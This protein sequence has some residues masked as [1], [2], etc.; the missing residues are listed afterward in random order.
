MS[1]ELPFSEINRRL[2][3]WACVGF[4][5]RCARREVALAGTALAE[6]DRAT[7][8]AA[9]EKA[10]DAS[11]RGVGPFSIDSRAVSELARNDCAPALAARAAL[12]AVAAGGRA[13]FLASDR[14][15]RRA[16]VADAAV[17]VAEAASGKPAYPG[18][19]VSV[20]AHVYRDFE[21]LAES[22]K[23]EQWSDYSGIPPHYFALNTEFEIVRSPLI[24]IASPIND[25]FIT[26]LREHPAAMRRMEPRAFE[27]LVARFFDGFGFAVE[28]T[29]QCR[30]GGRDV[31]A[32]DDKDQRKYLI[33]CKRYNTRKVGIEIVQRL[34]GV[35]AGEGATKG[36]IATTSA[37]T[38][39]A[40]D[41]LAL[42]TV[43]W[44]LEGRDFDGLIDWLELYD[45]VRLSRT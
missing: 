5:A 29:A 4:A 41:F 36:I 21:L 26:Y 15:A 24:E 6:A 10:E 17:A 11:R 23:S 16:A 2:P 28:L 7:I 38:K 3:L 13:R 33:E 40:T 42:N 35:V 32:I 20:S 1:V 45:A 34:N 12:S 37:F 27:E 9:I 31:V 43:K 39:P 19:V 30:D 25:K 8:E 14:K 44:R 18:S 22:A